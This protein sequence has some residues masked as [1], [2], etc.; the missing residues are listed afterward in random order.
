MKH[1]DLIITNVES[2]AVRD[3]AG[4]GS[5]AELVIRT[6]D[7]T[8]AVRVVGRRGRVIRIT[9]LRARDRKKRTRF[10]TVPMTEVAP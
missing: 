6:K 9:D 3:V 10:L 1:V 4:A 5:Q 7:G 2:I 8:L